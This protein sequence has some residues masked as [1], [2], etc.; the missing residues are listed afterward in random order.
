MNAYLNG[1]IS[2]W[3]GDITSL[4]VTAIANAANETLLGGGGVDGAIHAAAGAALLRECETLNGCETGGCKMTRGYDL[5]ATHVLH[6]VGPVWRG[7]TAGEPELLASC[8][9][10][11]L[12]I[13][14]TEQMETVAFPAISTGVYGYPADQAAHIAVETVSAHLQSSEFPRGVVLV[15]FSDQDAGPLAHAMAAHFGR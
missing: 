4:S 8:Y 9:R 6:C 1:R 12:E 2:L 3:T 5:P 11:A 10:N 14:E 15:A 13:A 7:G